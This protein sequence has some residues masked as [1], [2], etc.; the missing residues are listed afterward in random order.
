LM[1]K[2]LS[3]PHLPSGVD[4]IRILTLA[5]GGF[6]D[7]L[8]CSLRT[9][10]FS[11]KPRYVALSYTWGD[12][13]PDSSSLHLPTSNAG[14]GD[15][16]ITEPLPFEIT[17]NSQPFRVHRNL[18]V[19]LLH[20]RSTTHPLPLW[21]DAVC[22]NQQDMEERNNQVA[23][24]SFIYSR[25][26]KVVAWVG[27][28]EFNDRSSWVRVMSAER[29][30]GAAHQLAASLANGTKLNRSNPPDHGTL[31]RVAR[32]AYWTRLWIVQEA[33]LAYSLLIVFGAKVWT[34]EEIEGWGVWKTLISENPRGGI[35]PGLREML[36]LVEARS[37][38]HTDD[39][40][41]ERLVERF[42]KQA[43]TDLKD[44]VYGLLGLA[45]DVHASAGT[46]GSTNPV[47]EYIRCLDLEQPDPPEP[48][49]GVGR[50]VVNYNR[51]FY[52]I[53]KDA[54]K[55][56]LFRARAMD[57][58]WHP[59]RDTDPVPQNVSA[60]LEQERR[61]SVM[62]TAGIIQ[63][64]LGGKVGD[65]LKLSKDMGQPVSIDGKDE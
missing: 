24:M 52:D 31:Y 65:E 44:R 42:A 33:C 15:K 48:R 64:A 2:Q 7:P 30:S 50:V 61:I 58:L 46:A 54:V 13:Y 29:K 21:V 38:K 27:I 16:S 12:P 4:A 20:L 49:R 53:W 55:F 59:S 39:M 47:E 62:R 3:Y 56:V 28:R 11:T 51:S 40:K 8:V 26:Q 43:C 5:P 37:S 6:D 9:V 10:A 35:V 41:F 57:R 36:Q 22:I 17:V 19:C 1:P 60:I 14:S 45:N 18:Y 32:S 23:M 25:A 34:F 63:T